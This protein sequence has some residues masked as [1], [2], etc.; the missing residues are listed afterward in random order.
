MEGPSWDVG[1]DAETRAR[2]PG[3]GRECRAAQVPSMEVRSEEE[4]MH[5][6]IRREG[7]K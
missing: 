5:V 1:V 6:R 4:E 7:K 2:T 3:C